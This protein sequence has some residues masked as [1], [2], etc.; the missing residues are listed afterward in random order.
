MGFLIVLEG[1][2]ETVEKIQTRVVRMPQKFGN[3]YFH[4]GK[5]NY[6]I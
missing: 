4:E 5:K 2:S 3:G 1:Y 6:K